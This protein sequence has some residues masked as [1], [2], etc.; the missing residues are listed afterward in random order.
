MI[1]LRSDNTAAACPQVLDA[2]ARSGGERDTSYGD[3]AVT[4]RLRN[5]TREVFEHAD[6]QIFPVV[7]GTAANAL[8]LSAMCKPWGSVLCHESAHIANHEAG[9][10]SHLSGGAVLQHVA[11]TNGTI[12]A[13]ALATTFEQTWWGDP[14]VSQP[15]ALSLVCPTDLGTVPPLEQIKELTAAAHGRGMRC[16]LDGARIANGLISAGCSPADLTWRAG[17]DVVSF[18]ATKNGGMNADMIVSFDPEVS[19]ELRYRTKR[20]GHVPSKMCYLSA[21]IL[22]LIDSELWLHNAAHANEMA[23]LIASALARVDH[24]P[25]YPVQANLILVSLTD[26]LRATLELAGV[27]YFELQ[28]GIARF[29]TSWQTDPDEVETLVQILT[30]H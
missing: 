24:P 18:G 14:H 13:K 26:Q 21:Q 25:L 6:A 2:L 30:R 4:A 9:A 7:T 29:V 10:T 16:H 15:Q 22:A 11:G 12:D 23:T 1:D 19:A 3:D 27:E 8:A 17:I 28:P 20:A 5:R